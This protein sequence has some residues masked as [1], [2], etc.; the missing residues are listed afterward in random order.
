[1]A[2][3]DSLNELNYSAHALL[4]ESMADFKGACSDW[5]KAADLGDKVAAKWVKDQC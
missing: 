4:K 2:T 1:M 3:I 5:R